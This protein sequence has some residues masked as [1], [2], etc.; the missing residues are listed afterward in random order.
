MNYRIEQL[1]FSDKEISACAD[2]LT[3][4]FTRSSLFSRTGKARFDYLK[5]LYLE[6]P[7]GRYIG[8]CAWHKEQI[9]SH[10]ATVPVQFEVNGIKKNG[11]LALNLVTHPDHRGK[12]LFVQIAEETLLSA[13]KAGYEF[14]VGVANQNSS[15]GL[16]R[17]LGFSLIGQL[18]VELG[19]GTFFPDY[20]YPYRLK[21]L[22]NSDTLLWRL[23]NPSA[24]Y[25]I[26]NNGRVI[27]PTEKL[28]IYT[29]L[30]AR[31]EGVLTQKL[32][33][34]EIGRAHV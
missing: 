1:G 4:S 11:L 14:V 16:I 12:G 10:F 32:P 31:Q 22:W 5:W 15:H 24:K 17:K 30:T 8:Y 34:N 7:L 23:S 2:F 29:Q 25:F 33:V 3:S 20:N 27:T 26:N 19:A 28:G 6:N 9:V 18:R 21:A 13:K